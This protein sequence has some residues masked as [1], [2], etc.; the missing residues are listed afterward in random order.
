MKTLTLIRHAKS[1]WDDM[2]L[3]DA[4]RPLNRRGERD[5]P[6]MGERLASRGFRPDLMISS[7]AVRAWTTAGIIASKID[8]PRDAIQREPSLYLASP[9][10]ILDVIAAQDD[11]LGHLVLFGHN[12]GFTMMANLLVP[13]ITNNVPTTGIVSVNIDTS[14]WALYARPTAELDFFDYPKKIHAH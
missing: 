11:K 7:P 5:A 12:P 13:G 6:K 3:S 2:G 10:D 1:S 14:T 8:Y 9:D 4:Q